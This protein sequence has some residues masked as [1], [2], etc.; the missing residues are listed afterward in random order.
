MHCLQ[1]ERLPRTW[2]GQPALPRLSTLRR[3]TAHT[4]RRC[5]ASRRTPGLNTRLLQ[6]RQQAS[7]RMPFC[8]L[9]RS[10]RPPGWFCPC[11]SQACKVVAGQTQGL[12]DRDTFVLAWPLRSLLVVGNLFWHCVLA[13][14]AANIAPCRRLAM[15]TDKDQ[16]SLYDGL[17]IRPARWISR[18]LS[19]PPKHVTA[20][21]SIMI[22]NLVLG[23]V[24]VSGLT[25]R[26]CGCTHVPPCASTL[27]SA[28]RARM[29]LHAALAT[30]SLGGG[31]QQPVVRNG[32]AFCTLF[33]LRTYACAVPGRSLQHSSNSCL[34]AL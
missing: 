7:P 34:V 29:A 24:W 33:H 1:S 13:R 32:F 10:A 18:E 8:L 19:W 17:Q 6:T 20:A 9:P 23:F 14:F 21:K 28:C 3:E 27:R 11:Q 16:R 26:D 4:H 15:N 12:E 31:C 30:L 2:Q 5:R 22:Q 25:P